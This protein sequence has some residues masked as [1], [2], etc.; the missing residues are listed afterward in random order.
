MRSPGQMTTPAFLE[1][2]PGTLPGLLGEGGVLRASLG[3]EVRRQREERCNS[4]IGFGRDR[5]VN[6]RSQLGETLPDVMGGLKGAV[7]R[8]DRAGSRKRGCYERTPL[9]PSEL[10]RFRS[11]AAARPV[12]CYAGIRTVSMTWITPLEHWISALVT[13]ASLIRTAALASILT[14]EPW[15]VVAVDSFTTSLASTDPLT[16]W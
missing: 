5:H 16:T 15:S 3:V 4:I 10:P 6:G 11:R 8:W 2:E 9:F 7:P 12:A 13:V 14:S 1:G